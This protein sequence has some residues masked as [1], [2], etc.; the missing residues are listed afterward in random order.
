M[1]RFDFNDM[2]NGQKP[3][4]KLQLTQ[5]QQQAL[6]NIH[7]FL[8][9]PG[10]GV[11]ILK[12]YAGTGKTTLL[13][14]LAKEL[15]K[16]KKEFVLLAP[17]GRAASVLRAKTGFEAHTIHSE[18]YHFTHID[19][20]P[21]EDLEEPESDLYG[22]M[23]LMFTI[24]TRWEEQ[25]LRKI[26]IVD[27][28]SMVSDEPSAETSF[29]N[30]G[31]GHLL[32]D[33]LYMAGTNKI[34]FAGDPCQLPPVGSQK[35][36]ALDIAYF[37]RLG[38]NVLEFELTQILR[39]K[40]DSSVL[41][42]S[43]RIRKLAQSRMIEHWVKIPC[44]DLDSIFTYGYNLQL[45]IYLNKLEQTNGIEIIAIC[46]SNSEC[47]TINKLARKRFY[48]N[49]FAP[50]QIGD[51]LMVTQNNHRVPLVNGDFVKVTNTGDKEMYL[52]M[53]FIRVTVQAQHSGIEYETLL[54]MEPLFNGQANLTPDQQRTL[55][56]DFSKKMRRIGIKPKSEP[57]YEALRSDKYLNS[58]RANFGYAVTCHKSQ[59]GEWKDVY[60]FLNKGMY[61][62][63]RTTLTRW[64]YTAVTRSKKNLTL[65]NEWWLE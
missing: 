18:L 24:R 11:F 56:I 14:E 26:F 35:S 6:H 48:G 29:A 4:E 19:G 53:Y 23:R 2:R 33:L 30:F 43:Q 27:E 10:S 9:T 61:R 65:T 31:S 16:E 54:C 64:W 52:G 13:Q 34:I 49:E 25:D 12:G 15:K 28:A 37:K 5:G 45:E 50:L 59:G 41:K 51:L 7:I 46:N 36:P 42:L 3:E 57:Y 38:K 32:S 55:M 17:T 39:Q 21:D 60:L 62:M 1:H 40:K 58:L 47:N 44:K 63:P 8:R 20:E 22:Q